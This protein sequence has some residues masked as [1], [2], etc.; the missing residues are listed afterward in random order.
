MS[1]QRD[2][3]QVHNPISTVVMATNNKGKVRE[4]E[5]LLDDL[6]WQWR[7]L[8]DL[9]L[10]EETGA[11]FE[12]NAALKACSVCMSTGL[13]ALADD[14]GLEVRALHGEP[15]V[16][17]SRFGNRKNDLERNVFLLERLRKQE[18]RYACFVSVVVLAYPDG[19]METY[20]GTVEGE[21]LYGPRGDGGFGYD[22][23]FL[24]A[25]HTRTMAEM[26]LPEKQVLSH[27]GIALRALKQ[28]HLTGEALR[29]RPSKSITSRLD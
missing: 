22:P 6:G 13:P 26:T 7:H 21:I 19:H 23:L 8:D 17:S 2:E 18:D 15:G 3:Q 1:D 20:K 24:P 27:R 4:I 29:N 5:A 9:V 28:A 25:G 12:E 10:P 14:S 11:T 16:Y